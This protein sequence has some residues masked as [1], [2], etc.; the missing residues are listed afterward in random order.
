MTGESLLVGEILTA[1]TKAG[2]PFESDP[3]VDGGYLA[4]CPCCWTPVRP[5]LTM[6]VSASA[7]HRCARGCGGSAIGAALWDSLML[8]KQQ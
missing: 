1:L 6:A 5:A 2:L 3:A 8:G 7:S 4:G